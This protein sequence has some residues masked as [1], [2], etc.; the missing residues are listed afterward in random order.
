MNG[1][2]AAVTNSQRSMQATRVGGPLRTRLGLDPSRDPRTA[3][4][5][6]AD[7]TDR[8]G[9]RVE[10]TPTAE[11]GGVSG[12]EATRPTAGTGRP[13]LK[14]GEVNPSRLHTHG[15]APSGAAAPPSRTATARPAGTTKAAE[16]PLVLGRYRL[17]RRLG[18]GA[19]GTVWMARDE[20]L[21]RDVA[22]K[23]VPRE[24]IVPGRFEREARTAARLS[25][26]GIVTLYEAVMDDE[27]AY[28]VSEL[29]RGPTLGRL[30]EQGR[31]SDRD[32]IRISIALCDALA[33]AHAQGIVH[34]DV[35]PSNVLIPERPNSPAT[36]A[37]LTDFGVARVIGGDSLTV[38]GD[39]VGTAAY[40]APEQ[41][42]GREVTELADLYSLALVVYEALSGVNPVRTTTSATRARRLGAH[43]PPLRRQRR[44]LP[45]ELG[46]AIDQALR[47]RPRERGT[48]DALRAGLELSLAQVGDTPGVVASP[49]PAT[50][51]GRMHDGRGDPS[52]DRRA[53]PERTQDGR[54]RGAQRATAHAAEPLPQASAQATPQPIPWPAR[55]LAAT[56]AA[57]YA[58][59]LAAHLLS[60]PPLAPAAV[61][62]IAWLLV[63]LLPR[64]GWISMTLALAATAVVQ[65]HPG[66]AV[67]LLLGA[68]VPVVLM[69][70]SGTA[71]SLSTGAPALGLIGLAGVWPAV[72]GRAPVRA[73]RR[74]ALG[75]TGYV[76]LVLA[77]PLAHSDLY[78]PRLRG[79]PAAAV[80]NPSVTAAVH[81]LLVPIVTSGV[82]AGALV[83]AFAAIVLPW[84][85]SGRSP[86]R[87]FVLAA[88]WA[89]ATVSATQTAIAVVHHGGDVTTPPTAVAGAVVAGLVALSPT[90]L[91]TW[92]ARHEWGNPQAELP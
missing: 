29:V 22:V 62:V 32:V 79:A 40:M 9:T 60:P 47:P 71:W 24:R 26:P 72:A 68:L 74:A 77:S 2:A 12:N 11:I 82:L 41:A 18:A 87:D 83:W 56:A 78:T 88:V 19:F 85:V 33:Y 38:T 75:A 76:W 8:A 90:L 13:L 89:A 5:G 70:R 4:I 61:G 49:W 36:P 92:H 39:V 23:I 59:W 14:S 37:K 57:V 48:I 1:G 35:K 20:R 43:L 58:G 30:L 7:W 66:G 27:G 50:S 46:V 73:W 25:H 42:E 84:L 3:W 53:R 15:R 64:I 21:E 17:Q 80:W 67:V 44:E 28:L 81:D 51:S 31:L 69:P 16:V 86:A 34:R 52:R 10:G 65:Q 63:L 45:R 54:E 6:P 91:H 55:A